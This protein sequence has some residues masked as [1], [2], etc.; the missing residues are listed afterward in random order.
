[1][2]NKININQICSIKSVTG[3]YIGYPFQYREYERKFFSKDQKEGYYEV[4]YGYAK[5]L[6]QEQIQNRS[7]YIFKD[8]KVFRK[9][10]LKIRMSSGI[11]HEM[12]FDTE[13]EMDRFVNGT[14]LINKLYLI[15]IK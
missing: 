12:F 13:E 10:Y 9:P 2:I 6:T 15:N 7:N 5:L 4:S 1:M 3:K 14:W 8:K 11:Q